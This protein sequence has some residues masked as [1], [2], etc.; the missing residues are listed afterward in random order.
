M[1]SFGFV[2]RCFSVHVKL[3]WMVVA[4]L[5]LAWLESEHEDKGAAFV[6]KEHKSEHK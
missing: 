4:V 5:G 2:G 3:D 6:I 1:I